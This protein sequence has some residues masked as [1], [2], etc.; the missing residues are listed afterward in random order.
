MIVSLLC[1]AVSVVAADFHS[2]PLSKASRANPRH[3]LHRQLQFLANR[4]NATINNKSRQSIRKLHSFGAIPLKDYQN[5]EYY[6]QIALGTPAQTFTVIF[7]T[8]SSNLWVP[9]ASCDDC[10]HATYDSSKSSSYVANGGDFAL[11]YGSGAVEGFLSQDTLTLGTLKLAKTVFGE[12]TDFPD[13][14]VQNGKF[15]GLMGM[16]WPALATNGITPPLFVAL[17][18]G[19]LAQPVF[20]FYLP[21]DPTQAGVLDI[22]GYNTSL[23][24]GD[25]VWV[26]LISKSYWMISLDDVQVD[27]QSATDASHAILD[28]GTSLITGP[29]DEVANL[30]DYLGAEDAGNGEYILDCSSVDNLP[31]VKFVFGGYEF[32]VSPDTYVIQDEED[33]V[34]LLGF[35]GLDVPE[36][37]GG[38]LWILG[39]VFLRLF[40]SVYDM[41]NARVGLAELASNIDVQ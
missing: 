6:G 1:L 32:S 23:F 12:V 24:Q 2:I 40:F 38:P 3:H 25:M 30:A 20:S 14:S 5:A 15:D 4:Y 11:Q 19:L 26:N 13:D 34:C 35:G 39:D 18:N 9:S 7:D 31:D 21:S 33:G 29:S 8:G 10:V 22:G 36:E 41:K 37:N 17:Q 27:G 28:T 16:G